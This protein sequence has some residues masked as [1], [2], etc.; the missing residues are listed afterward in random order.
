MSSSTRLVGEPRSGDLR[1]LLFDSPQ[2]MLHRHSPLRARGPTGAPYCIAHA[3]ASESVSLL[4]I[5]VQNPMPTQLD[6]AGGALEKHRHGP[7]LRRTPARNDKRRRAAGPVAAAGMS[8]RAK[9]PARAQRRRR[10]GLEGL[11][12]GGLG[13]RRTVRAALTPADKPWLAAHDKHLVFEVCVHHWG[14]KASS[15]TIASTR[16]AATRWRSPQRPT[17]SVVRY[18]AGHPAPLRNSGHPA[19]PKNP[20]CTNILRRLVDGYW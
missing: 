14:T 20:Q 12:R 13:L 9:A 10:L 19:W 18:Q 1:R 16:D 7:P 2:L 8:R 15:S 17:G 6:P 11:L 3:P 5:P 4:R